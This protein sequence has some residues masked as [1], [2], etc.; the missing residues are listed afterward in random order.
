MTHAIGP[1]HR[2]DLAP[3]LDADQ[4]AFRDNVHKFLGRHATPDYIRTADEEKRFPEE[5]IRG[6]ADQGYFA[7]TLP[8]EYGGIGGYL[9]MVAMLEV[10]G[11]HS[12][13]LSRYWNLNVNMVGGA[14]ARFASAEIKAELLPRL[15]EGRIFFAFA[16]SENGAGSDAA[17]LRMT[18]RADGGDF[19]LNGT[20]MWITGALQA[21]YILTACR[22]DPDAK[23]H[24]GI[25]LVLVPRDAPGV[26]I[27]P[28]DMLGGH[29][30]R[31]CEVHFE[32]VRVPQHRI[33]GGLHKGWRQLTTVLAKERIALGAMCAGAAQAACDLARTYAVERKQFGRSVTEFQAVSHKLVDMQTAVD[34]GR[35]LVYRAARLLT[36]DKPC[37][38]QSSQAKYF[39]SDA[40]V[41]VA[42]DGLQV[43]GAN[44]Y[45]TEY[46]MERHYREAKLFQIFGGTNEIQRNIVA[47]E[48]LR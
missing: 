42:T 38:A 11:Y 25:T 7:V 12:V 20:K 40:Y 44:G 19:V 35:L 31:T 46:A 16:L 9:D 1:A 13:G 18:A 22:T 36:E 27:S 37:G 29:A 26:S 24:D 3:Y 43:M 4:F 39:M 33:V 32:D 6:M 41:S 45:C 2:D 23:A 21:D 34:A 28:I 5:V 17:S 30:I 8:E 48:I 15:A 10:I 14:I 47:R